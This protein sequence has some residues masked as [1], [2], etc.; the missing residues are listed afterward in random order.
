VTGSCTL[1]AAPFSWHEPLI[2][3]VSPSGWLGW[4]KARK[5]QLLWRRIDVDFKISSPAF[6]VL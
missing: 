3:V 4:S 5:S 2:G 1:E 6:F